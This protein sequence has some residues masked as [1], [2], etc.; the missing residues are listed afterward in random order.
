[1]IDSCSLGDAGRSWNWEYVDND[2][3]DVNN[4]CVYSL[5]VNSIGKMSTIVVF[6]Q[7]VLIQSDIVVTVLCW[8]SLVL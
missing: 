5:C 6:I 8:F 7:Y 1:M 4:C 3:K 2:R